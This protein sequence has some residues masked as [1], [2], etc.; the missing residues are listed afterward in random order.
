[1]ELK[2]C[3]EV[4]PISEGPLSEVQLYDGKSLTAAQDSERGPVVFLDPLVSLPD[5]HADG[6]GCRVEMGDLQSLY[7]LPVPPWNNSD[8]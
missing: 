2:H 1:M 6:G 5:E 7:H 3:R 4:V 8:V